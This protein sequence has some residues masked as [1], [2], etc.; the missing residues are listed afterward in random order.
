MEN[1][2]STNHAI[3]GLETATIR[4]PNKYYFSASQLP[5]EVH[6]TSQHAI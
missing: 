5:S 2:L 6:I 4:H 1:T 3:F